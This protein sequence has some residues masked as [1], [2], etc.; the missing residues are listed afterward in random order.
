ML[1]FKPEVSKSKTETL[2]IP[3]IP[4]IPEAGNIKAEPKIAKIAEIAAPLS[5]KNLIVKCYSPSDLCY[6]V[7]ARNQVH[8]DFLIRMNPRR[9]NYE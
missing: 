6:E 2:A 1:W 5:S 3:A 7:A 9:P 8:A 4:A